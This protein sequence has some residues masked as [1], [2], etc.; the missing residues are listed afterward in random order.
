MGTDPPP[1][2]AASGGDEAKLAPLGSWVAIGVPTLG[3]GEPVFVATRGA[4]PGGDPCNPGEWCPGGTYWSQ[5]AH[6]ALADA[7]AS[8]MATA[9]EAARS[10]P[11]RRQ[12]QYAINVATS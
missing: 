4:G 3:P 6:A 9:R 12:R 5:T 7:G 11:V 2:S 8:T 10:K 1:L